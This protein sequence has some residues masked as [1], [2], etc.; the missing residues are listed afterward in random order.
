M[1]IAVGIVLSLNET[2][3]Y[4]TRFDQALEQLEAGFTI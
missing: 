2:E 3:D 4:L 1:G